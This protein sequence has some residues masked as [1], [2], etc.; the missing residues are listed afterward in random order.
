MRALAL[1]A[2]KAVR[3]WLPPSK[4][5]SSIRGAVYTHTNLIARD[6]VVKSFR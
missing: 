1:L 2:L 6:L 4:S 5:H 3:K